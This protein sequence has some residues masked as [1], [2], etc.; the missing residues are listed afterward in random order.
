VGKPEV[1]IPLVKP[2]HRWEDDIKI[3]LQEVGWK[4]MDWINMAQAASSCK[5]SHEPLGCIKYR[6][7]LG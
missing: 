2:T 7:F 5:C 3:D 1:K 4:G 6:E